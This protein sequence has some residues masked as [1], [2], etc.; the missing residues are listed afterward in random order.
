MY[1]L[2]L[3]V[4]MIW[5]LL[6]LLYSVALSPIPAGFLAYQEMNS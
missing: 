5:G 6:V 2:N 4:F 3:V 1:F